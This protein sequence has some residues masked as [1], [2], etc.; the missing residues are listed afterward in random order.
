MIDLLQSARA[1]GEAAVKR[2][3]WAFAGAGLMVLAIGF[4][5][6]GI[7]E[8]LKLVAPAWAAFSLGAVF[9]LLAAGFCATRAQTPN[10]N[11]TIEG[12][13]NLNGEDGKATPG[14]DGDWRQLL[15]EALI[16]E[17][18]DK[19]AR[20]AAIAAIAGLILGAIEGLDE[21]RR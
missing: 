21:G 14:L 18:R 10:T 13:L 8:M 12:A 4:A 16:R 6:A 20:A 11:A 9:L 5:A 17:S 3:V 1:R 15:N 19:P 2:A 7:V